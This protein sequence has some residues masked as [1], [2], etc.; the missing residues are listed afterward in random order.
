MGTYKDMY[1]PVCVYGEDVRIKPFGARCKPQ[2]FRV[3]AMLQ[4]AGRAE[5]SVL[6]GEQSRGT[7]GGAVLGL[8]DVFLVGCIW[9]SRAGSS[10]L[11]LVSETALAQLR[12]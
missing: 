11:L 12:A 1:T 2:A 5:V 9:A 8:S 4:T 3:I 10:G 7:A 6:L